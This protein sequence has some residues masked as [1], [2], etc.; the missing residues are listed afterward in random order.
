MQKWQELARK[1]SNLANPEQSCDIWLPCRL[2]LA[3][4]TDWTQGYRRTAQLCQFCS[5]WQEC[6]RRND[7][8]RHGK[9]VL[10]VLTILHDSART[11][12]GLPPRCLM[13]VI[14]GYH[15]K[16]HFH[17]NRMPRIDPGCGSAWV[18]DVP[19]GV[20]E[21]SIFTFIGWLRW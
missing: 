19:R 6:P 2:N 9:P 12:T 8:L 13:V 21:R 10:T 16:V 7:F 11:L 20:P 5:F 4:L 1:W 15:R 17:I 14:L 18:Q 3:V